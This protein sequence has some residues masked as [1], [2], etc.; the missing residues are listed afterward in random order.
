MA[1]ITLYFERD[2]NGRNSST[3]LK[4]ATGRQTLLCTFE[5]VPRYV[6]RLQGLG[7]CGTLHKGPSNEE[8]ESRPNRQ[9]SFKNKFH[10]LEGRKTHRIGPEIKCLDLWG[11]VLRARAEYLLVLL[12]VWERHWLL[13]AAVC[14]WDPKSLFENTQA[15]SAI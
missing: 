12:K 1:V 10:N 2:P 13:H 9:G 3:V 5:W 7:K 6:V 14:P 4:E 15:R 8:P 11:K